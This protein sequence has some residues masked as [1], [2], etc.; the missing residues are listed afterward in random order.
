QRALR[1]SAFPRYARQG[2][3]SP[4]ALFQMQCIPYMWGSVEC[5]RSSD[6][7]MSNIAN[8]TRTEPA[9]GIVPSPQLVARVRI[10]LATILLT[11]VLISFRPFQPAGAELS[12]SGGDTL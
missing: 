5:W 6:T 3:L 1:S 2:D 11:V 8:P 4:P 7:P 10:V 12:S 9:A